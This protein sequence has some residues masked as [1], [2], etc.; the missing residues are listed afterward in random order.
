MS[1]IAGTTR[2]RLAPRAGPLLPWALAIAS[3]NNGD[4]F[5][6]MPKVIRVLIVVAVTFF[7][8][9]DAGPVNPE[10]GGGF[11][12]GSPSSTEVVIN[13][14][15]PRTRDSEA[16]GEFVEIRNDGSTSVDIS[17]WQVMA[18]DLVTGTT[19]YA[20]VTSGTVLRPGCHYLIA[21]PLAAL[22][23][24]A[25]PRSCGL[26]DTGGLALSD[27]S[28][29]I[30]DQVGMSAPSAY[31][32]GAPLSEFPP[33]AVRSSYTRIGNDS[34]NNLTDFVFGTATPQNLSSSCSIR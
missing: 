1:I 18:W 15:A 8:A 17:G 4:A 3:I 23:R 16:C 14:F 10:P 34:D 20:I 7:V 12:V 5:A 6:H 2:P 9:C 22:D 31:K 27:S 28:G 13:E 26:T 24:D 30:V 19:V 33:F 25:E 32:E 11:V 21:T 29:S